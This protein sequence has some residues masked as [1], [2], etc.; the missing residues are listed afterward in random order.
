MWWGKLEI[1]TSG[2]QTAG[3]HPQCKHAP[4]VQHCR[5]CTRDFYSITSILVCGFLST[6]F[7]V[8]YFFSHVQS[9][10]TN[11]QVMLILPVCSLC[12]ASYAAYSVH[13]QTFLPPSL[14][15]RRLEKFSQETKNILTPLPS[16]W[17]TQL[18]SH[19]FLFYRLCGMDYTFKTQI[20]RQILPQS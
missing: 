18:H 11:I 20:D 19:K 5:E 16:I 17:K 9:F 6:F 10:Q 12:S 7:V 13:P 14:L 1:F 8:S 4:T 3:Q 15:Q 2:T